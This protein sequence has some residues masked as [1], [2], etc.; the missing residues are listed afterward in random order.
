MNL[1]KA[2]LLNFSQSKFLTD[3]NLLL[4][5][6]FCVWSLASCT[7]LSRLFYVNHCLSPKFTI[8]KAYFVFH[9][10][11]LTPAKHNWS[12]HVFS[13]GL[14][15]HVNTSLG[16]DNVVM[17]VSALMTVERPIAS[18]SLHVLRQNEKALSCS[19]LSRL[20]YEASIR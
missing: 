6:R 9:K 17:K 11:V 18:G 7:I 12:L 1:S 8:C 10:K 15:G 20:S 16:I 13:T 5:W 4:S 2:S 3:C 19:W 14:K